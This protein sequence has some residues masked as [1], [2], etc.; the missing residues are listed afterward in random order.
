MKKTN[1]SWIDNI[2]VS[3]FIKN[4]KWQIEIPQIVLE[5]DIREGT[6]E[7]VLDKYVGHFEDTATT[8]G[9]ICLAAH[10]R[11]YENNY[12]EN[13]K[14]LKKGDKIFYTYY[15]VRKKFSINELLIIEDNNWDV[16]VD[17][18]KSELTLI[19]CMEDK[20]HLRRCLK[21]IEI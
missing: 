21:A 12:F 15:G 9:N 19:T 7:W 20:P 3:E 2:F 13:L 16:L 11:G 14:K 4:N 18:M 1:N 5:T 17:S 10:N 6:D 8:I